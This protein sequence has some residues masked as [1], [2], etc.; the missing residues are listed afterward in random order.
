MYI[1]FAGQRIIDEISLARI[2][3]LAIPPA[4]KFVRISPTAGSKLQAI[5]VDGLGRIQY[6]Y[7]EKFSARQ[8]RKKF[9]KIEK[10]GEFLPQ[11]RR[12]TNEHIALDGFPREK[13]LA[14]MIRLINSLY[15]RMGSEKSVRQYKTYGITTLQNRHLDI[16]SKGELIFLS[17]AIAQEFLN[18]IA[19]LI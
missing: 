17:N 15:I 4:W 13:V 18:L 16:R 12:I 1:D 3:S 10:F 9:A 14:I 2:K 11:L 19:D 7:H 6:L 8:Q 5:G